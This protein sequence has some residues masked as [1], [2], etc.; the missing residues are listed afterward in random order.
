MLLSFLVV[1][2]CL[3]YI[4]HEAQPSV[5][6]INQY[7]CKTSKPSSNQFKISIGFSNI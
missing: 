4:V 6:Q 2:I 3:R 5:G 7:T 1:T